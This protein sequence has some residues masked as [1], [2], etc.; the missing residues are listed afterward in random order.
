MILEKGLPPLTCLNVN[1]P[2]TPDLKGVKV[3][4]QAKGCWVN[5]WVTC[6]RLDDHNYFWLTGSFTDHELE[7]RTMIIGRWKTDMWLSRQRQSI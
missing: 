2:D 4:E 1:F 7:M 5:E 6:P 3:C